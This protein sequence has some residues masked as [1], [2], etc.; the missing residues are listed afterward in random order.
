M[1]HILI[2]TLGSLGDLHPFLALGQAL[3]ERG[4]RVTLATSKDYQERIELTGLGFR[5]MRPDMPDPSVYAELMDR[6]RG[7]EAIVRHLIADVAT[8]YEDL[9]EA[10]QGV[11]AL[12]SSQ[13]AMAAPI[14]AEKLNLPRASAVLQPMALMSA[15]DFPVLPQMR[16]LSALLH[17]LG[18]LVGTALVAAIRRA[19]LSWTEPIE[20]LREELALAPSHRHPLFDDQLSSELVL[21]MFPRVLA[22]PQPDWPENVEITGAAFWDQNFL[23]SDARSNLNDF[24]ASGPAP[25]VFTLGSAAVHA[26]GSFYRESFRAV[27]AL[28]CRAI[29][30]T[31][32]DFAN[33]AQLPRPLPKSMLALPYASHREVFAA[34]SV[35]VHQGGIG[36]LS[37][38]LRAG[39]PMLVVP[40]SHDQ[41]DNARRAERL[42]VARTIFSNE[43]SAR[44]AIREL[45]TLL[46]DY[47]V[48]GKA[49]SV[50]KE[51]AAE[52]GAALACDA[53]EA[54]LS[55]SH[56]QPRGA[57]QLH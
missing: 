30:L 8:S 41:P 10:S 11:D 33:R 20:A 16:R 3:R 4:H 6:R 53:I 17:P 15:H 51:V 55:R 26:S 31:G 45:E 35:V 9:A 52:N 43:Y 22:A 18:A 25:V 57:A 34:A 38:A 7:P 44:R 28:G 42:G 13:V 36:T 39:K 40:F 37:Q 27:Q 12:I 19:T 23:S 47:A 48:L 5:H 56:Q 1:S 46:N 14:V 54:W 49:V 24:L 29:F 2:A 32:H 50:G 21:A